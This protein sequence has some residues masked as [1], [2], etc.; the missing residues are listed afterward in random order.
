MVAYVQDQ[1]RNREVNLYEQDHI[2]WLQQTKQDG[3]PM[4]QQKSL[5]YRSGLEVKMQ[6]YLNENNIDFEYESALRLNGKTGAY[7]NIH[8]TLY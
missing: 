7:V 1:K 5:G 4:R 6:E 8:Q 2:Q 3:H